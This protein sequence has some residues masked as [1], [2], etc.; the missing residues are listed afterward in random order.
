MPTI[1]VIVPVYNVEKYLRC[2]V[3]SILAQTYTDIEILLVDDGSTDGSSAICDEYAEKD[4]RVQVFHKENGGV[5]S[6]RNMGLDK[7]TGKWIMFVDSDDKVA[8]QICERLL[9]YAMESC[10]PMCMWSEGNDE[11]GYVPV[12]S[13]LKTGRNYPIQEIFKLLI[14]HPV[15]RL[16]E[17]SIV[18]K[19]KLRFNEN[20]SYT[21]DTIFNFEYYAFLKSFFIIDEP[22]YYY[23][24][25]SK[26]LSHGSFIDNYVET[27]GI[28]YKSKIDLALKLKVND[29]SVFDDINSLYFYFVCM[30]IENNMR[31]DAPGTWIEKMRRNNAVLRSEEFKNAF[32][33]RYERLKDFNK[34][35]IHMLELSYYTGSY[36][37]LWLLGVP[38]K[39]KQFVMVKLTSNSRSRSK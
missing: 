21:E 3:D 15:E 4:S 23:R 35:Y 2:C 12:P 11:T 6:A 7:A 9:A 28:Y 39:I 1:S 14:H 31:K 20:V 18:E 19:N 17:Q 37:W 25:L 34:R 36:F 13:K 32:P 22:L 5:S 38:G 10:M 24:V 16:Y 33:Y 26:S 27:A 30:A 8:P 29:K